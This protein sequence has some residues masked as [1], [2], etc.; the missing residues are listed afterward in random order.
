MSPL[1]TWQAQWGVRLSEIW[2]RG[3]WW[4]QKYGQHMR[5]NSLTL[6][7]EEWCPRAPSVSNDGELTVCAF[8]LFIPFPSFLESRSL[9]RFL[10]HLT[11]LCHLCMHPTPNLF[12]Q[13]F[14]QRVIRVWSRWLL[15]G[16]AVTIRHYGD[17]SIFLHWWRV[18]NTSFLLKI[19]MHKLLSMVIK[20]WTAPK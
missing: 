10:N 18:L 20:S 12:K 6:L 11:S 19:M 15:T 4:C 14:L 9:T 5:G 13:P 16:D 3:V 1:H 17:K 2:N 8:S 7:W